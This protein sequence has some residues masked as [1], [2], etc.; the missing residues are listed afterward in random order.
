MS[1]VITRDFLN[2]AV[3]AGDFVVISERI[4][5]NDFGFRFGLISES[6]ERGCNVITQHKTTLWCQP[7]FLI[8]VWEYQVPKDLRREL[9]QALINISIASH[10]HT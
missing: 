8:R 6:T 7:E 2:Q 4:T 1:S 3:E 9:T 5:R 10:T